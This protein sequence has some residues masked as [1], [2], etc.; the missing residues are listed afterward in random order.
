MKNKKFLLCAFV[1]VI[2][3]VLFFSY[4]KDCNIEGLSSSNRDLNSP[5][6][7]YALLCTIGGTDSSGKSY[8][9][10]SKDLITW[11]EINKYNNEFIKNKSEFKNNKTYLRAVLT[12]FKITKI[13][14]VSDN[15]LI[16]AFKQLYP[17]DPKENPKYTC[18]AAKN[19][20]KGTFPI[21]EDKKLLNS[22]VFGLVKNNLNKVGNYA[23][24]LRQIQTNSG[25]TSNTNVKSVDV[26][27]L[28]K[29]LPIDPTLNKNTTG[30]PY[31][32]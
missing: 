22:A 5:Q 1:F 21:Y 17:Y 10:L 24:T 3:F 11:V 16:N 12:H 4:F 32:K 7:L 30:N 26:S 2:I 28:D 20:K 19:A 8:P 14:P 15:N 29:I 27:N 25:F 23:N 9:I 6:T 13:T 18:T 31:C